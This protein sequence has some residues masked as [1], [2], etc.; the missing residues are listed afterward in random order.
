MNPQDKASDKMIA[1]NQ[2]GGWQVR[3]W[4]PDDRTLLA[5]NYVSINESSL[6][7][8]DAATGQKKELTP[9]GADKVFYS[10]IGFSRDGK[11]IT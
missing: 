1:E 6:W 7:L 9:K 2:G 8:I 5:E 11:G 3:D 4:S 10:A